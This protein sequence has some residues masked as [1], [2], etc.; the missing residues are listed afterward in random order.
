MQL[1][2]FSALAAFTDNFD[3]TTG[4]FSDP[5]AALQ[6]ELLSELG[7]DHSRLAAMNFRDDRMPRVNARG[8][9]MVMALSRMLLLGQ[10][11]VGKL[12]S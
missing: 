10:Y 7:N 1:I 12:L 11:I 8:I 5:N 4:L 6:N 2:I 9:S 3:I